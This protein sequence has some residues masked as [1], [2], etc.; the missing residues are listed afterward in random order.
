M[1][2]YIMLICLLV[3]I[4]IICL[5]AGVIASP[6]I[7]LFINGKEVITDVRVVDGS[8]YIPISDVAN[9]IGHENTWID[10]EK[11]E[12][13]IGKKGSSTF[14]KSFQNPAP[15]HTEVVFEKSTPFEQYQGAIQL[16]AVVRGNKALSMLKEVE[17]LQQGVWVETSDT[18]KVDPE[19]REILLAKVT[20]KLTSTSDKNQ[21]LR[22]SNNDFQ[23]VSSNGKNYRPILV[24]PPSPSI[25][26]NLVLGNQHTGWVAMQI[27]KNESTPIL[28]FGSI[29]VDGAWLTTNE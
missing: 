16:D 2:R 15:I 18:S 25:S 6:G 1:K 20:I 5:T 7:K 22:I 9:W 24:T 3:L 14:G 27:D 21:S 12:L 13:Y 19:E 17:D 26:T 4:S 29:L 11:S 8:S 23:L 10:G 28:V